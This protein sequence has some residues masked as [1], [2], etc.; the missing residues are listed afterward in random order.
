M[1]LEL[2]LDKRKRKTPLFERVN[3]TKEDLIEGKVFTLKSKNGENVN[4][5]KVKSV[6]VGKNRRGV[7]STILNYIETTCRILHW[8]N[9]HIF[10]NEEY[11]YGLMR[12]AQH[13]ELTSEELEDCI[14][15]YNHMRLIKTLD[16]VIKS[17]ENKELGVFTQKD[18]QYSLERNAQSVDM[19]VE[20]LLIKTSELVSEREEKKNLELI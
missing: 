10:T 12:N 3:K 16:A 15:L 1:G 5:E 9:K 11:T 18:Y 17:E 8:R 7:D 20:E 4:G 14:F 2:E 13:L 19:T 6:E